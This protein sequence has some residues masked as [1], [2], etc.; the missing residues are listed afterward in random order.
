MRATE[1]EQATDKE[2][3]ATP[4]IQPHE[5]D[6]DWTSNGDRLSHHHH[7]L[8]MCK[9]KSRGIMSVRGRERKRETES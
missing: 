1:T 5:T 2:S 3:L 4:A 7:P 6:R 9:R 8:S